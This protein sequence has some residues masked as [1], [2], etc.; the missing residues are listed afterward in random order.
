MAT[1][2]Q[3]APLMLEEEEQTLLLQ[4]LED[5]LALLS[6]ERRATYRPLW[7]QVVAG[8]VGPEHMTTLG[9]VVALS[10]MSGRAR[11][12]YTAEGERILT[13]LFRRTPQGEALNARLAQVNRAL[14]ALR[15]R[16]LEAM[17]VGM[18]TLGHF[19]LQ[20]RA[21]G[22][23]LTLTFRPHGVEVESITAG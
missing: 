20:V 7:E 3:R 1:T 16:P 22:V 23:T 2:E 10:L 17:R 6:V 14:G 5:Y 18:R 15:N 11:R 9:E 13:A 19:T 12:R 8:H 21:D 4:E